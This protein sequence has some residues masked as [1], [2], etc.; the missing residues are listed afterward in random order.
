[1]ANRLTLLSRDGQWKAELHAWKS[2]WIFYKSIGSECTVYHRQE[3]K[4]VWG[5][6]TTDWVEKAAQINITNV[7]KGSG[8]LQ[9][10]KSASANASYLELKEWAV[11][12]ILINVN[13]DTG[14]A[15]PGAGQ[16]SLIVDS[17]DATIGVSIGVQGNVSADTAVVQQ[18]I[19]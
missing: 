16:A 15:G 4:N 10:T 3:T 14:E 6:T 19:W 7:Y 8:G 5:N 17:V 9:I 13:L 1:M 2:N 11:G 18:S 12:F